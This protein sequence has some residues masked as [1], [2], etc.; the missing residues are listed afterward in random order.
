MTCK[1]CHTSTVS[2]N[3]AE[4]AAKPAVGWVN[5]ANLD[6]DWKRNI[7]RLHDEKQLSNPIYKSALIKSNYNSSGLLATVDSG[8]PILCAGCHASNAYFDKQ[9]RYQ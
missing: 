3:P 7:L 6:K 4:I 8:K 5:D 9:T 1:A 2:T